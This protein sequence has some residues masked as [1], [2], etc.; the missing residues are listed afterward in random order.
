MGVM[1]QAFYWDCPQAE[2][3]VGGWWNYLHSKTADLARAGVTALWLPPAHKAGNVSGLSMGYDPYDYYDLG[4]FDQK[5]G[6]K[7]L[8]GSRRELEDLIGEIHAQG[9]Q[10]Y[11]DMVLN[12]NNGADTTE[13]NDLDHVER[14]TLFRPMSGRFPRDRTSFHPNIYERW[15]N[16]TFGDMPDLC[17]RNPDIYR[18]MLDL[19]RWLV[20]EIGFDG[21]RYDFVK[22]Y[23]T[24]LIKSIQEYR[25][26]RGGRAVSPY[27]V[28]EN[29][30]SERAIADWL[31]DA[32]GWSDNPVGAF[33]FP[34]RWELKALCDSYGYDLRSLCRP[35]LLFRACPATAVTFVDNHDFRGG[36]T[37]E[38]AND[39]LLAYAFILTH[40]GYP[41]VYWKDYAVYGLAMS[42]TPHGMDALIRVHEELADGP[43]RVLW[44]DETLYLMQR[45]GSVGREGLVLALNNHGGQWRGERVFTGTAGGRWTPAA[46]WSAQTLDMPQ[47]QPDSAEGMAEFWAPPRGYAVYRWVP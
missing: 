46:W 8:F 29:W 10:A 36:D 1:M 28:A 21:F 35:D 7:T 32:N 18:G 38:I 30:D 20:E 27:A 22:G 43:S 14:W 2:N 12:H 44:A 45:T 42:G 11:A 3:R 23:G 9:L 37:P 16:E 13:V 40:E 25:Y 5:G 39:K 24:W 41:C 6:I 26:E 17:H 33:D 19:A 31:Q 34:L 4:E 47:D 15:D